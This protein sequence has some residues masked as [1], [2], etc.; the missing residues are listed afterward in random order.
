MK[1][2]YLYRIVFSITDYQINNL[3]YIHLNSKENI[4]KVA[5]VLYNKINNMPLIFS[6]G[7]KILTLLFNSCSL[8]FSG[9][10]FYNSKPSNREQFF[11]FCKYKLFIFKSMIDF[12][13]K[14]V[15]FIF[16][17]LFEKEIIEYYENDREILN[18]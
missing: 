8:L 18:A 7:I 15:L 3:N 1:E 14:M 11:N 2:K 4:G 17:S 13:E 9:R 10:F 12:Y 16:Y 6:I 5:I